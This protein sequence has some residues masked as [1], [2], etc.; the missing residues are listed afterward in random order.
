MLVKYLFSCQTIPPSFTKRWQLIG[1]KGRQLWFSEHYFRILGPP[2]DVFGKAAGGLKLHWY[3][4]RCDDD[5]IQVKAA[6][7]E[8]RSRDS[9]EFMCLRLQKEE[10]AVAGLVVRE[11]T[12]LSHKH[13][14]DCEFWGEG[15]RRVAY[16]FHLTDKPNWVDLLPKGDAVARAS[17]DLSMKVCKTIPHG[18]LGEWKLERSERVVEFRSSYYRAYGAAGKDPF[19]RTNEELPFYSLVCNP[20]RI[21]LKLYLWELPAG[22][23]SQLQCLVLSRDGEYDMS[24]HAINMIASKSSLEETPEV[25]C[26]HGVGNGY[27][28]YSLRFTRL[29]TGIHSSSHHTDINSD[30][31]YPLDPPAPLVSDIQVN[32]ESDSTLHAEGEDGQPL[33]HP[34]L[35]DN[36][37]LY[38]VPLHQ[39]PSADMS[40]D[41]HMSH[42]ADMPPDSHMLHSADMPPDSHMSHSADVSPDS[43]MSHSTDVSPDS[44]MSHSI[45][46]PPD[47]H[48]LHSLSGKKEGPKYLPQFGGLYGMPRWPPYQYKS[49][50]YEYNYYMPHYMPPYW[51]HKR[52]LGNETRL[53]KELEDD[54]SPYDGMDPV[55]PVNMNLQLIKAITKQNQLLED[56]FSRLKAYL[57]RISA[58]TTEDWRQV[59]PYISNEEVDK[60]EL[61]YAYHD[62]DNR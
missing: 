34:A 24:G 38:N 15:S 52:N 2:D 28:K 8:S 48:M 14:I 57:D 4:L 40:P 33:N 39:L 31:G 16:K 1:Q 60:K 59:K 44:H 53:K 49:Y 26:N 62:D 37:R 22:S 35:V 12:Q 6:L 41:S 50:P 45:D 47:S 27:T 42:S 54:N 56:G 43:H 51:I 17:G 21:I 3:S 29:A 23:R 36:H 20:R 46:V 11:T 25:D 5:V 9:G 32:S 7:S 58:T 61:I 55:H 10:G 18:F 30:S 13:G 19:W